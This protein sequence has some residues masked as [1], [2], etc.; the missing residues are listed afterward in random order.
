MRTL[1]KSV[2]VVALCGA[3]GGCAALPAIEA[4]AAILGSIPSIASLPDKITNFFKDPSDAQPRSA[5][6][7]APPKIVTEADFLRG[8]DSVSARGDFVTAAW[9]YS[10]AANANPNSLQARMRLA[11]AQMALKDDGSAYANYQAALILSPNDAD[12]SMRLG[13]IELARGDAKAALDHFA[14]AMHARQSDPKLYNLMGVAFTMQA[15][16]TMARQS[17]EV[18]LKLKPDYASLQNNYGMMQL[19]SGDYKAAVATFTKLVQSPYANDRYRTNRALAEIA[20]GDVDAAL[21][22][23][24]GADEA[25]LRRTL[26]RYQPKSEPIQMASATSIQMDVTPRG[27]ETE[28]TPAALQQALV[29]PTLI[30]E[31]LPAK[32]TKSFYDQLPTQPN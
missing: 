21:L 28:P 14:A 22:D 29:A 17:F 20:M 13:E 11:N 10:K 5:E 6:A 4:G 30:P 26:A 25:T 3:M 8:G 7:S 15:K 24:P 31:K 16:Y 1:A 2:A 32:V 23:A 9:F 18:G 27:R 19:Q 12:A